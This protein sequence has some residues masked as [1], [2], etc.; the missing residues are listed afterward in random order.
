[1]PVHCMSRVVGRRP[2]P[3]FAVGYNAIFCSGRVLLNQLPTDACFPLKCQRTD[4]V[5]KRICTYMIPT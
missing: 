3:W 2:P 4:R 5:Y 1:M